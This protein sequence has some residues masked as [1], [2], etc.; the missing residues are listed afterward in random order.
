MTS[1]FGRAVLLQ[2]MLDYTRKLAGCPNSCGHSCAP[3]PQS[4]VDQMHP[5]NES[6]YEVSQHLHELP[7]RLGS[8]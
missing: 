5:Q 8:E 4:I 1:R 3:N 7:S 2:G 6:A